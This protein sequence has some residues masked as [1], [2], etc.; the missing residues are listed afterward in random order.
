MIAAYHLYAG[1][2]PSTPFKVLAYMAVVALDRDTEPQF[3]EGH[4]ALAT[5]C[6]GVDEKAIDASALRAVRRAIT[7]LFEA[8]AITVARHSSGHGSRRVTVRYRLHLDKP[9]PDE[10]RA[11]L[12]QSGGQDF[13]GPDP[14]APDE[15][16]PVDNSPERDSRLTAQDDFRPTP[17]AGIGRFSSSHRTVSGSAPDENRPPK[18]Y[19]EK[20]ELDKGQEYL[21][22]SPSP[23]TVRAHE[24][25]DDDGDSAQ[26]AGQPGGAGAPLSEPAQTAASDATPTPAEDFEDVRRRELD[27][28]EAY[29]RDHPEAA[30]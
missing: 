4:E 27:R 15:N 17:N 2:L 29:M 18:E 21:R 5:R 6:F 11:R 10:M 7:P 26:P 8:G 9:A 14:F 20:E 24:A 3:W 30:Q 22:S 28:L 25:A 23:A 1:K 19:E 13:D 12:H 16:R